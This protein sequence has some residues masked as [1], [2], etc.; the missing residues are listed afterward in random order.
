MTISLCLESS[1][2]SMVALVLASHF[3]SFL[4]PIIVTVSIRY[5]KYGGELRWVDVVG[6]CV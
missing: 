1:T 3:E 6:E 5:V 2:V 4:G